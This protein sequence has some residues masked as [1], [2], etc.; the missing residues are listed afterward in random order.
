MIAEPTEERW[1]ELAM[2]VQETDRFMGWVAV[3]GPPGTGKT[4]KL[5]HILERLISECGVHP[6]R[7]M[8]ISYTKAAIRE[9]RSRVMALPTIQVTEDDLTWFRTVHSSCYRLLGLGGDKESKKKMVHMS[10]GDKVWSEFCNTN[11]MK[12]GTVEREVEG[13]DIPDDDIDTPSIEEIG[14]K[15]TEMAEQFITRARNTRPLNTDFLTPARAFV[16]NSPTRIFPPEKLAAIAKDWIDLLARTDKYDFTRLIEKCVRDSIYPEGIDVIILDE[17]QDISPLQQ[18]VILM[19]ARNTSLGF[20]GFDKDQTIYSYQGAD[21][22]L[23]DELTPVVE[24]IPLIWS[25][26]C[27]QSIA[28]LAQKIISRNRNRTGVDWVSKA[29]F[30]PGIVKR[31]ISIPYDSISNAG[32]RGESTFVLARNTYLLTP[33]ATQLIKRDIPFHNSKSGVSIPPESPR[34]RALLKFHLGQDADAP[35][36]KALVMSLPASDF[37]ENGIKGGRNKSW[38]EKMS[39]RRLG[40]DQ[41]NIPTTV[42]RLQETCR[43]RAGVEDTL[44][45]FF[46]AMQYITK[47]HKSPGRFEFV[48]GFYMR[49]VE[50]YGAEV[51][52]KQPLLRLSTIHGVKGAEADNVVLLTDMSYRTFEGYTRTAEGAESERRV[53][54]VGITRAKKRLIVVGSRQSRGFDEIFSCL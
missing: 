26:R 53:F 33:V 42:K 51:V 20:Y 19:W 15:E 32:K 28:D 52:L 17:A 35:D 40:G 2:R 8:F 47:I 6:S 36:V 31:L 49:M 23:L 3:P 1:P 9:A 24:T 11:N 37:I 4:T 48:A 44:G 45:N 43:F 12:L 46:T 38:F 21:P 29:A 54:Y 14:S 39:T 30:Q 7:I 50:K 22:A 34:I 16:A 13:E 25:R 5:M 27:P 41:K 10:P 18:K